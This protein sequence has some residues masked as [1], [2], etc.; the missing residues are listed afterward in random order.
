MRIPEQFPIGTEVEDA[1][2]HTDF[3]MEST[4]EGTNTVAR[5]DFR[6]DE[7]IFWVETAAKELLQ[8]KHKIHTTLFPGL[9][10]KLTPVEY[11]KFNV[12]T[13]KNQ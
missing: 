12:F 4:P 13:Y 8:C 2:R 3:S 9:K 5:K 10:V 6:G 7:T 1:I 11:T